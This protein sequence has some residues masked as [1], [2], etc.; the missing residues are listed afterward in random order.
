[1]NS[2]SLR[3]YENNKKSVGL[4]VLLSFLFGGAGTWY[5]GNAKRGKKLVVIGILIAVFTA[6]FGYWIYGIWSMFDA[7]N[8]A[9]DFNMNLLQT[10]EDEERNE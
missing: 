9:K 6:G 3:E 5:A 7:K 4:A 1:M 8:T 10:L 2:K